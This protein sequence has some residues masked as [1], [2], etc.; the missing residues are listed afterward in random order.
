AFNASRK[1]DAV[2]NQTAAKIDMGMAHAKEENKPILL[3]FTGWTC[4]NCRRMEENVWSQPEIYRML[5]EQYVLISLYVDDSEVLPTNE[6][7]DFEFENGRIKPIQTIG[8][9]WGT[10]QTLNFNSTSLPYYVLLSPDLEVLNPP[11]NMVDKDVYQ[12]WLQSGL[13]QHHFFAK[14]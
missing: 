9:K 10:F 8:Q 4:V 12:S 2:P 11:V 7:F 6:Q 3:D 14:R 13:E 1:S 5:K